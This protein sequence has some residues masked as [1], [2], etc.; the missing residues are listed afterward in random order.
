MFL[1]LNCQFRSCSLPWNSNLEDQI[2]VSNIEDSLNNWANSGN[3]TSL[4]YTSM[5]VL[6]SL[7]RQY[8]IV[9]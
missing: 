2:S 8:A 3:A 7:Q 4:V 9:C 6:I 1:K 5:A